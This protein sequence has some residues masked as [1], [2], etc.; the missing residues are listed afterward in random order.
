MLFRKCIQ[1]M[2]CLEKMCPSKHRDR[3]LGFEHL[4]ERGLFGVKNVVFMR[5]YD[6]CAPHFFLQMLLSLLIC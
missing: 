2:Q 1:Q 5:I 6:P 4:Q 3:G